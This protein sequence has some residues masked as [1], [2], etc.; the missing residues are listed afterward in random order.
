MCDG[1]RPHT[2]RR[3][4]RAR[5]EW[6]SRQSDLIALHNSSLLLSILQPSANWRFNLTRGGAIWHRIPARFECIAP[7]PL[8]HHSGIGTVMAVTTQRVTALSPTT[9]WVAKFMGI[10]NLVEGRVAQSQPLQV[11]TKLGVFCPTGPDEKL[12]FGAKV[13]LQLRFDPWISQ[14]D[15]IF[16]EIPRLPAQRVNAGV[17]EVARLHAHRPRYVLDVDLLPRH[18]RHRLHQLVHADVLRAA[19]IGCPLQIRLH[20]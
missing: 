8:H 11:Q 16:Q 2:A 7:A 15:S 9:P 17:A 4:I 20:Q 3:P 12:Q 5:G 18:F 1:L 10:G 19:D 6:S 14:R 13:L